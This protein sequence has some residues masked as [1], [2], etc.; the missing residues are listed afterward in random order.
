MKKKIDTESIMEERLK[1]GI[2]DLEMVDTEKAFNEML[3]D[4]YSFKSVGG[5]FQYLCPSMV[6]FECLPTDY[7]CGLNDYVDAEVTDGRW[8]EVNGDYYDAD[9]VE[10]LK[11]KI[12][13]QIE[14]EQEVK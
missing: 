6:L 2:K 4:C 11:D 10:K 5:P 8:E 7:R 14:D 9:E 1:E 12:R 13:E 3:D